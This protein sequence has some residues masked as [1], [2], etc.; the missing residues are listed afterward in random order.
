MLFLGGRGVGSRFFKADANIRRLYFCP[1]LP[2]YL[3]AFV[4]W[5]TISSGPIIPLYYA[6]LIVYRYYS[7]K[8]LKIKVQQTIF[9]RKLCSYHSEVK[10]LTWTNFCLRTFLKSKTLLQ[11]NVRSLISFHSTIFFLLKTLIVHSV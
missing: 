10:M 1:Q 9:K 3:D 8:I 5:V 2:M 6:A 7:E 4:P 11:I